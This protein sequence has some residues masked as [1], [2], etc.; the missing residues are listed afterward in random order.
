MLICARLSI[1]NTPTVSAR[2]RDGFLVPRMSHVGANHLQLGITQRDRLD[3]DRTA[4]LDWRVARECR[5]HV[6]RQRQVV[7]NA[8]F[9]NRR[10]ARIRQGHAVVDRPILDAFEV[11]FLDRVRE[12]IHAIRPPRVHVGEANKFRGIFGHTRG[13]SLVVAFHSGTVPVANREHDRLVDFFH[14]FEQ[15]VRVR[16]Q[17]RC[18]V[19]ANPHHLFAPQRGDLV[20]VPDVDVAIYYQCVKSLL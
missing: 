7:R 12:T 6:H 19:R 15:R 20:V 11:Q 2:Q 14:C 4:Q 1:W 10:H 13:A 18:A 5:A 3:M 8:V 16:Q 9:I 17:A